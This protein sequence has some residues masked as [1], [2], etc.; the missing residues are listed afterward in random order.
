M[1]PRSQAIL[2][3][4]SVFFLGAITGAALARSVEVRRLQALLEG[5]AQLAGERA[6]L[7]ALDRDVHLDGPQ[8]EAVRAVFAAQEPEA[9]EIRRSVAPRIAELR[10]R[11]ADDV[12][13]VLRPDQLEGFRRFM[14]RQDAR[15]RI[16]DVPP[17]PASEGTPR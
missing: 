6:F 3:L 14:I 2:L 16:L 11:A 13:R 7:V 8:R 1:S 4:A 5:P 12:R 15:A 17:P 10:L 9:K